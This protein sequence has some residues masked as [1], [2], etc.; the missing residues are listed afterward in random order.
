MGR[1]GDQVADAP[2]LT[3][4][5]LSAMT[6]TAATALRFYE[7][8][9][10]LMPVARVSGQR[11]YDQSSVARLMVIMFCSFAGLTLDEIA[12]VVN[13][14]SPARGATRDIAARQMAQIDEQITRLKLARSMM[15][16]VTACTC[17]RPESCECGAMAPVIRRLR[18]H[19]G[20][21]ESS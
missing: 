1:P 11:R 12:V 5:E 14:E 17:A 13:D 15:E 19:L 21:P 10:L 4:G 16:A 18:R 20:R 9:G 7:Q 8:R 2:L 3:I 6:G